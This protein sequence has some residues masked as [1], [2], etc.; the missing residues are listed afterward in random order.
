[1]AGSRDG[2]GKEGSVPVLKKKFIPQK[3]KQF[4]KLPELQAKIRTFTPAL[5]ER[6]KEISCAETV[7]L[8]DG[9]A[10]VSYEVKDQIQAIKLL[11]AYAFGRPPTTMEMLVID[12]KRMT[13][14]Q[15]HSLVPEAL[16]KVSGK[17]AEAGTDLVPLLK[18]A[19]T[20]ER[21]EVEECDHE[22]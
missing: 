3:K 21:V 7:V 16:E 4:T 9:S 17:L 11:L 10:V 1:M 13:D 5:I 8:S 6:L 19:A 12:P 15:L 2:R 14:D 22:S 20:P 18:S